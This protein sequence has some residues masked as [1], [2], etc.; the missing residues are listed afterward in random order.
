MAAILSRAQCIKHTTISDLS[1]PVIYSN[2][3]RCN[4]ADSNPLTHV[5]VFSN[6]QH[7]TRLGWLSDKNINTCMDFPKAK[8]QVILQLK[9]KG[10]RRNFDIIMEAMQN[11]CSPQTALALVEYGN[12]SKRR[13]ICKTYP[14]VLGSQGLWSC[15]Y[16]CHCPHTSE[17]VSYIHFSGIPID[18]CEIYLVNVV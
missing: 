13:N 15:K 5:Y 4:V 3:G 11:K 18:I 2:V 10:I 14:A 8:Q 9:V 7:Y 1:W 17:C 6:G 12:N 16:Q